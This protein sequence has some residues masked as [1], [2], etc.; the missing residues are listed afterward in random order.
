M[1]KIILCLLIFIIIT[2]TT[3]TYLNHKSLAI[4]NIDNSIPI[5]IKKI[6]NITIEESINNQLPQSIMDLFDNYPALPNTIKEANIKVPIIENMVPQ[7]MTLIKDN[8]FITYYSDN[9]NSNSICYIIDKNGS[10]VN[11]VQLD[12]KSHVGGLAYDEIN[13]LIYL[14]D[15]DGELNIYSLN[16]FLENKKVY[17]KQK[18]TNI[19][20]GLKSYQ[21]DKKTEID[22]LYIDNNN[23]Y[24]GN[25][26]LDNNGLVKKYNITMQNNKIN[27]TFQHKFKVPNKVQ[28]LTTK[29]IQ[30]KEYIIFSQ[31]YRRNSPSY[32][33]IYEYNDTITDFND[34][35]LKPFIIKLPPMLEQ[36]SVNQDYLYT[37]YESNANKYYNCLEKVNEII[38]L[39]LKKILDI[40]ILKIN[41]TN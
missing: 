1:K 22:Y 3:I 12:M 6:D 25:F 37:L 14:P 15:N 36:I 35:K 26:S 17:Y 4:T 32:L 20:R 8:I 40:Y 30:N 2:I 38:T 33:S 34:H 13:E 29:E 28:G 9:P 18:I 27:L 23:L 16:D 31:S 11:I 41:N 19:S 10:L 7:G 21:N 39:D 24:I 5:D